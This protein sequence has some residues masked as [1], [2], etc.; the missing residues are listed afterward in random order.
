MFKHRLY[1]SYKHAVEYVKQFPSPIISMIAKLVSYIVGAFAA[2]IIL[3]SLMDESLLEG[4]VSIL[5]FKLISDVRRF[6]GVIVN[7]Y[8]NIEDAPV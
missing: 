8:F 5:V 7:T 1:S 2:V 3:I 4:H 6:L